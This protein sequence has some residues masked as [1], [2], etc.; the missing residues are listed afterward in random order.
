MAAVRMRFAVELRS[1]WR[2]WL[3]VALLAGL[4]GGILVATAASARRTDSAL[5]RY[6]A[7]YDFR[8]ARVWGSN[9]ESLVTFKT[10]PQVA[11]G[12]IG[13]DIGFETRGGSFVHEMSIYASV[14]G[15]DGRTLDRWKVLAGRRPNEN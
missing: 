9:A 15:N 6:Q 11:A 4:A 13:A 1:H 3:A 10:L 8:N 12:S 2:A 14:D 7:A 5:A